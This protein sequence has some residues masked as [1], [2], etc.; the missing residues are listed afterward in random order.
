MSVIEILPTEW[1][2]YKAFSRYYL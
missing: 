2:R 1:Y